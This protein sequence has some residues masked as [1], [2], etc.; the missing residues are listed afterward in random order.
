MKKRLLNTKNLSELRKV[1]ATLHPADLATVFPKLKS[2]K[3]LQ[4]YQAMPN[5]ELAT[6]FSYL[7]KPSNFITELSDEQLVGVFNL[8]EIDDL[9]DI[10]SE[11]D[12]EDINNIIP[13][14]NPEKQTQLK[15]IEK[16][17]ANKV[18]RIIQT[19]FITI[20]AGM[21]VKDAMKKL[22]QEA[23]DTTII[24]PLF[25]VDGEEFIGTLDLNELI[26]ARSPKVIKEITDTNPVTIDINETI[27][28]ATKKIHDYSLNSLPVIDNNK[29]VGIITSDDA[30][31]I[32]S[33]IADTTYASLAGVSSDDLSNRKFTSRLME[34]L[35]WLIG[36]L[37]LSILITNVMG[38]FEDIIKQVTILIFFQTLILDMAGNVG[39]QSLA[40][41]IQT[42][43][44][45]DEL[46]NKEARKLIFKEVKINL[47]NSIFLMIIAFI[48]CFIF[49]AIY[50]TT[51]SK[52]LLS[53]TIAI[54]M[55]VTLIAS[56]FFGT[57]LPIFF[58]KMK[59]NPAVASGPLI[60]TIN[61]IIAILIYFNLAA[62]FLKLI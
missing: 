51:Y 53:L 57:L 38:I 8:I 61:D 27:T 9:N 54:A 49:I 37:F 20:D 10:L 14:L 45:N 6:L 44:K 43:V 35:P 19:N 21:D 13:K 26:I 62:L 5:E 58:S 52:V 48:V 55:G 25:V 60:T 59:I 47:I 3:R 39:T 36:L 42:L 33:E 24:D 56:A 46:A 18:G 41:T 31:E 34:R 23:S 11:L 30:F 17:K 12:D 7:D 40:S 15:Y 29:L 16:I 50:G 2:Q 4:I 22:I 28:N 1:L 32:Y